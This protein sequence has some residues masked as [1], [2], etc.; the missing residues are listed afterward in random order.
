METKSIQRC[1]S[2]GHFVWTL[3]N[4]SNQLNGSQSNFAEPGEAG[5]VQ[6]AGGKMVSHASII[7]RSQKKRRE[8][9]REKKEKKQKKNHMPGS[10]QMTNSS[11]NTSTLRF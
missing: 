11:N 5:G 9:K 1:W 8:K 3:N 7:T 6:K 4:V 10:C 2:T